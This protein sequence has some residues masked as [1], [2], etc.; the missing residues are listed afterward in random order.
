MQKVGRYSN[1]VSLDFS[2]IHVCW[3]TEFSGSETIIYDP[4]GLSLLSIYRII[5]STF[6]SFLSSP[7]GSS[8]NCWKD[9]HS[10]NGTYVCFGNVNCIATRGTKGTFN[11]WNLWTINSNPPLSVSN[12]VLEFPYL[13]L[14][15]HS[16]KRDLDTLIFGCKI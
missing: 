14:K 15:I 9:E 10:Y 11:L 16:S 4:V 5:R 2:S 13:A 7:D 6:F 3:V 8:R 12:H 1:F